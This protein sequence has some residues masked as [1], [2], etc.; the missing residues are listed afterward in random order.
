MGHQDFFYCK[1]QHELF[2]EMQHTDPLQESHVREI[3]RKENREKE[4]QEKIEHL[5]RQIAEKA[6]PETGKK[7]T[8]KLR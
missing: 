7:Y 2:Q 5:L 8:W 1:V 3:P 6:L 4:I